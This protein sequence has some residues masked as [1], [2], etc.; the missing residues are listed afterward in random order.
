M[1]RLFRDRQAAYRH[2]HLRLDGGA[3]FG[4]IVERI[5]DWLGV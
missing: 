3:A 1:V 2:A 5:I 4:E